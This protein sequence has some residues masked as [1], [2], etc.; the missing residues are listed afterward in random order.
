MADKPA[1]AGWQESGL[2]L[3]EA[4]DSAGIR[5]TVEDEFG[6]LHHATASAFQPSLRALHVRTLPPDVEIFRLAPSGQC[7]T[8]D[9]ILQQVTSNM[10]RWQPGAIHA[11]DF[12]EV[13]SERKD[14]RRC[15]NA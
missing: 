4:A 7:S 11:G 10:P 15:R 9:G 5:L 6:N 13:L 14:L 2:I 8:G 3:Q 12:L 1:A